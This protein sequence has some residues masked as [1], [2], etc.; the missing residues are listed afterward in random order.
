MELASYNQ[1]MREYKTLNDRYLALENYK[2]ILAG[3]D[4]PGPLFQEMVKIAL[5][6]IDHGGDVIDLNESSPYNLKA[7][8]NLIKKTVQFII[9]LIAKGAALVKELVV[10]FAGAMKLVELTIGN[11]RRKMEKLGDV[12]TNDKIKLKNIEKLSIDGQFKGFDLETL[13]TLE[14]TTSY[15]V[16]DFPNFVSNFSRDVTRSVLNTLERNNEASTSDILNVF[17]NSFNK[18]IVYPKN[19]ETVTNSNDVYRSKVLPGNRAIVFNN[20]IKE[21]DELNENSLNQFVKKNLYIDFTT[22]NIDTPSNDEIQYDVPKLSELKKLNDALRNIVIVSKESRKINSNYDKLKIVVQDTIYQLSK[23]E[24]TGK[25][26]VETIGSFES[27]IETLNN[28]TVKYVHWLAI[29]LNAYATLFSQC[30]NI[31]KEV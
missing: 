22:L 3:T 9:N 2:T 14:E 16:K 15:F 17:S 28:P 19:K 6:D 20:R 29:T 1:T 10:K 24:T 23:I 4:S 11:N 8:A 31:Y 13:K 18:H 21:S 7:I 12:A 26:V 5:E 27:I 25:T 30:I